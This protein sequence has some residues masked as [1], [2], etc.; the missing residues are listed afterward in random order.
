MQPVDYVSVPVPSELVPEVY[1]LIS[2]HMVNKGNE[3]PG[4]E[5]PPVEAQGTLSD[6][7]LKRIWD[8]SAA[9]MRKALKHLAQHPG[10]AIG[11]A[12]LAKAVFG[13]PKGHK[14]AGAMGAFGRRCQNRYKKAKPFAVK[15]NA[16][17]SRW[18]YT[19]A[20]D[21]A[22]RIAKF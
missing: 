17:S 16:L 20:A 21:V 18:E 2:A 11:A 1:A 14:L 3:K 6:D 12:D 4:T 15:W 9:V 19:M 7:L 8:E 22:S 5:A 13:N 10:Q